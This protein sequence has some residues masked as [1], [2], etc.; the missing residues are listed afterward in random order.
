MRLSDLQGKT[1]INLRDGARLGVYLQPDAVIDPEEGKV[2]SILIPIKGSFFQR[3]E[4]AV[5]WNAIKRI[6]AELLLVEAV[7]DT[8]RG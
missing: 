3:Y 4:A 7:E 5:P 8:G 6:G 1:V 2:I